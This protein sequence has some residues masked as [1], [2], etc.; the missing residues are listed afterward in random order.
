MD[1]SGGAIIVVI[2][3]SIVVGGGLVFALLRAATLKDPAL[4]VTSV[5]LLTMT[6][7]IAYAITDLEILG[8]LAATG[9]GG[10][11]TAIAGLY[12]GPKD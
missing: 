8:G 2:V 12:K 4:V 7:L 10:L 3:V 5:S 9:L 11:S 1:V 6:A